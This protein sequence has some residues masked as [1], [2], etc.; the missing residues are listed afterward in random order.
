[1]ADQCTAAYRI[2]M[3]LRLQSC[4]VVKHRSGMVIFDTGKKGFKINVR[5]PWGHKGP[6]AGVR[7][8]CPLKLL[9]LR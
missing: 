6:L 9:T 8:C 3:H 4:G 5:S 7:G 1:M 2:W